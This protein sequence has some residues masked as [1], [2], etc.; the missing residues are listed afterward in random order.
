MGY[1]GVG[2]LA[3]LLGSGLIRSP[4]R[5]GW[6]LAN[7][8]ILYHLLIIITDKEL[9][10]VGIIQMTTQSCCHHHPGVKLLSL[11]ASVSSLV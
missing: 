3:R 5:T 2:K 1:R 4:D 10:L 6:P 8:S 7:G 11:P 9:R